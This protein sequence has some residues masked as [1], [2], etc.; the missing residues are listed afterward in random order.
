MKPAFAVEKTLGKLAKWL[1]L[2][3]F[4][5]IFEGGL[6]DGD[7]AEYNAPQRIVLTR[8]RRVP[9]ADESRRR[10]YVA[11]NDPFDQLQEVVRKLGIG[12]EDIRPF[13]RCIVCNT[14]IEDVEKSA[15]RN[16]VPDYIWQHQARF[17]R[18][19][20]CRRIYWSG[21]HTERSLQRIQTL[22]R[23]KAP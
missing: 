16:R 15:V 12:F 18:C 11:P 19:P 10:V 7:N 2:L 1:R 6:G 13:S 20:R 17:Q 14:P 3:G 22:F 8:S 5:A 4:D 21:S 23:L 9:A